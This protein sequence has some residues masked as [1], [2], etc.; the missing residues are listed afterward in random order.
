MYESEPGPDPES[1]A[2]ICEVAASQLH[3]NPEDLTD[4]DI[5]NIN[6]LLI[7]NE[8]LCDIK[9]VERFWNTQCLG[10]FNIK[11]P[12]KAIPVWMKILGKTGLIDA[13]KRVALDLVPIKKLGFI[14]DVYFDSVS[15][16][17]FEPLLKIKYIETLSIANMEIYDFE[18]LRKFK[19]LNTLNL[20]NNTNITD[21]QIQELQKAL[22]GVIITEQ[23]ILFINTRGLMSETFGKIQNNINYEPENRN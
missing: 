10:L 1:E 18:S 4:E 14:K 7:I 11:Y 22:L 6:M 16:K 21:K 19:N 23:K 9:G 15:V 3:K 17:S 13:Q 8:Q 5:A 20:Y 12:D 2:L